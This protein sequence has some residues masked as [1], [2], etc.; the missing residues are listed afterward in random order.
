MTQ[1]ERRSRIFTGL[2]RNAAALNR[3]PRLVAARPTPTRT[4]TGGPPE[5]GHPRT[6][7]THAL[8]R[9]NRRT[10]ASAPRNRCCCTWSQQRVPS[11]LSVGLS[12]DEE[13]DC[14]IFYGRQIHRGGMKYTAAMATALPPVQKR[15][16]CEASRKNKTKTQ[17]GTVYVREKPRM[18]VYIYICISISR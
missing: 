3:H 9:W 4:H 7:T 5:A 18:V 6:R 16:A 17:N 14:S 13:R 2:G 11:R 8:C 10:L 12:R 15:S 1:S